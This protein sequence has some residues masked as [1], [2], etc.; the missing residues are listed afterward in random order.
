MR[1]HFEHQKFLAQS[2]PP[3]QEEGDEGVQSLGASPCR[4]RRVVIG[5]CEESEGSPVEALA[6]EE[7]AEQVP[8]EEALAEG[9]LSEG[10]YIVNIAGGPIPGFPRLGIHVQVPEAGGPQAEELLIDEVGDE[11]LIPDWNAENPESVVT[12]GDRIIRVNAARGEA[13]VKE[14]ADSPHLS[15]RLRHTPYETAR[16]SFHASSP[17]SYA[18]SVRTGHSEGDESPRSLPQLEPIL[19]DLELS[20][21]EVA[22]SAL[23]T[24]RTLLTSRAGSKET[25]RMMQTQV[26]DRAVGWILADSPSSPASKPADSP[27]VVPA[28]GRFSPHA[29]CSRAGPAVRKLPG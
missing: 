7:P 2:R 13:M 26:A 18:A 4:E 1:D 8:I 15:I 25:A 19:T 17:S 5:G 24:A 11:G 27:V 6:E 29:P 21:S 14:L 23:L 16:S 10:E 28:S 9:P 3:H 22:S 12:A 20:D